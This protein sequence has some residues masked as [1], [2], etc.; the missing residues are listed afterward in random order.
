MATAMLSPSFTPTQYT[1]WSSSVLSPHGFR[2][3][4][5]SLGIRALVPAV[6]CES[7]CPVDAPYAPAAVCPVIRHPTDLSQLRFSPLVLATLSFFTTRHR[8]VCFR[9]SPGHTPARSHAPSFCSNVH[10]HGF[11]PLPLGVV[12]NPLLKADPEG[13]TLISHAAVRHVVIACCP[14]FFV[15]LQH[16]E[17]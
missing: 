3:L 8:R 17:P 7:Q 9:S 14:P 16:T 4:C 5:F 10:D 1:R 15:C 6:P 12:W 2:R 11:W 13:P